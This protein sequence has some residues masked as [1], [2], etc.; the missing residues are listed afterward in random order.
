MTFNAGLRYTST[1]T[2]SKFT[3]KTFFPFPFDFA[4]VK[5]NSF[6]G[7]ASLVYRPE[8]KSKLSLSFS[9]GFRAPNVDDIG[10]LFEVA[11]NTVTV[12]NDRLRPE[13]TKNI[14]IGLSRTFGERFFLGGHVYYTLLKDMIVTAPGTYNGSSVIQY[15]GSEAA[16]YTQ[17][18]A[19]KGHMGGFSAEMRFNLSS[20]WI[21]SS[22]LSYVDGEDSETGKKFQGV[23]PMFGQSSLR[24]KTAKVDFIFYAKYMAASVKFTEMAAESAGRAFMHGS[25][26]RVPSWHTFNVKADWQFRENFHLNVGIENIFDRYYLPYASGI[27]ELGRNFILSLR[28]A[29]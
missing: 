28:G 27:P 26:E 16:V 3:D 4:E 1:R 18:N 21:L 6:N 14:E 20:R 8:E 22:T 2:H 15:N 17:T 7:S 24:C 13:Y 23:V 29:F 19:D 10:K 11:P 25:A 9:T 12:P 5:A